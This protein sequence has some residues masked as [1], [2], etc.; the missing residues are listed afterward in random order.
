MVEYDG[1]VLSW[2]GSRCVVLGEK[3][4]EQLLVRNFLWVKSDLN[5]FRV[6]AKVMVG[7]VGLISSTISY[8]SFSDSFYPGE[9]I[10]R[11]PKAAERQRPDVNWKAVYCLKK[12]L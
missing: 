8:H 7:W 3:V 9:E 12:I 11:A 5:G 4:R 2:A 1:L 10:L 6:V